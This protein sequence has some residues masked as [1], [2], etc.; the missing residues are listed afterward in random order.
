MELFAG[1]FRSDRIHP[2]GNLTLGDLVAI[3]PMMDPVLVLEATGEQILAGLENGV[4]AFP[5]LEGR[6][7]QVAGESLVRYC[8]RLSC[9]MMMMS[10]LLAGVRFAFDPN[11]PP[12]QRIVPGSVQINGQPLELER[13]YK[14]GTKTYVAEGKDGYDM[15]KVTGD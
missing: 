7:P 13:K 9:G 11:A 12:K 4:C 5:K 1:T 2:A 6:F 10:W 15:F 8:R 14:L 3:L